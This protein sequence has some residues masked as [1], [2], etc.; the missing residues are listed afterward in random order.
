M[1]KICI[2]SPSLKLGGIER[3]LTTL[4]NEF[5]SL[6]HDVHFITCLRAEHFYQ[7]PIGVQLYEPSFKRSVSILN[8]LLFYPRLLRY[9]R[10]TVNIIKP[11]RVLVFGDWFSP[12][13][14]LALKGIQC[15]VYISDRTLPDYK[16][17]FPIP[18][19]K[20]CL[21]PTAAGFI[22]QSERS[23]D[24]KVNQFGVR[25]R[26]AVIPNALPEI[27]SGDFSNVSKESKLIYVGRFEW[28]KDPEIL[29]RAMK[30]ISQKYSQWELE[31]AGSGSLFNK[32]KELASDLGLSRHVHFLGKVS[33][34][35]NLYQSSSILVLPSIV[36]GFPNTLIE[37][38][39]FG[40][41]SI[42]FSD[43]PYEDI[44]NDKLDGIVVKKRTPEELASAI[45]LL[46]EN[47]EFRE[48]IGNNAIKK[49]QRFDKSLIAKRYLDFMEISY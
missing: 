27:N 43:I 21:Y 40:L 26:I 16:F 8:K 29:I 44:I 32:M 39:Y 46:I 24:F 48:R 14:L 34:V 1:V 10:Q 41:P 37:G 7:L 49:V 33:N 31:M 18:L 3:A 11:A 2:V 5:K 45:E 36:E 15:P 17:K 20:K 30:I 38:M 13:T 22:A 25:L 12:I 35:G 9:I 4:A 47:K 28:E 6:G 42:C 19:L 23:K